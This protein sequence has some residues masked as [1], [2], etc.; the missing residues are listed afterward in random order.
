MTTN[1]I[2]SA[3]GVLHCAPLRYE[4][5]SGQRIVDALENTCRMAR[6]FGVPVRVTFGG[7][8]L[9]V[10]PGATMIQALHKWNDARDAQCYGR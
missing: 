10:H 2:G 8:N 7:I 9:E 1:R 5:Y 3:L 6:S 4:V